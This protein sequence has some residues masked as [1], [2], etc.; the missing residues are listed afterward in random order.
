MSIENSECKAGQTNEKPKEIAS[1]GRIQTEGTRGPLSPT[2]SPLER[3]RE[4]PQ[5]L[6]VVA[7]VAD[8][9]DEAKAPEHPVSGPSGEAG[10]KNGWNGGNGGNGNGGFV[11]GRGPRRVEM[12]VVEPWHEPVNGAELLDRLVAELARFVVFPRWAAETVA[13]WILHTFA[14]RL[15][16]VTAYLGIESP[17]KECGKSTLLMLLSYFVDRPAVSSNISSSAFYH[18]IEEMDPTLLLDEGDTTLRGRD[19]LTGIFNGGYTKHTAYVW[20]ISYDPL[21][22]DGEAGAGKEGSEGMSQA[23]HVTRY[24]TWCPKAIATIGN[25]DPTLASR[26][27]VIRMHRKTENE[28]CARLK[29]L[30]ATELKRKCARFV[31][32]HAEE[33]A[34]AEPQI[35]KGLTNRAADIW[36]PL[37]ALADAA[38]GRW[39]EMAREAAKGLTARAQGHSPAGSLLLDI[40]F[41]FILGHKERVF[42]RDVVTALTACDERP[43]AELRKGKPI[44][45]AWL[46]RQLRP[47]GITPRTMRIGTEVAKGYVQ[48]EM[49]ETFRRYIPKAE[50]ERVKVELA[51]QSAAIEERQRVDGKVQGA[52]G[53]GISMP[54][55]ASNL[56]R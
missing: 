15:R 31:A 41:V 9:S 33:I 34:K 52:E 46:A 43:W 25:L 4:K 37:L 48:E 45:E 5:Q 3:E 6:T 54:M 50:L 24:S 30:E 32:D 12:P 8:S 19:E 11:K 21:P 1:L 23:G 14:F 39:P 49:M 35:P 38:G 7:R 56:T 51:E 29:L 10:G 20:R 53:T 42:S 2:L 44:T 13:L 36:E 55:A 17:E 22:E 16:D 40:F 27:I 18:V 26:C 47:Y 28:E